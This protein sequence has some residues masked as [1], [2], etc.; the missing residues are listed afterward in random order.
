VKRNPQGKK[1]PLRYEDEKFHPSTRG[2]A[3]RASVSVS[4]K[5]PRGGYDRQ[6]ANDSAKQAKSSPPPPHSE[7]KPQ[8]PH[9]PKIKDRKLLRGFFRLAVI[10]F[11]IFW[12]WA[13]WS[14]WD[15]ALKDQTFNSHYNIAGYDS[16]PWPKEIAK[17][18]FLSLPVE[19]RQSLARAYFEKNIEGWAKAD[20]YD[21]DELREW[22]IK[23]ATLSLEEAP[24][25]ERHPFEDLPSYTVR[26]RNIPLKDMP[27]M[28]PWRMLIS[29]HGAE[30]L[31]VALVAALGTTL[32]VAG[33]FFVVRW[34]VRGFTKADTPSP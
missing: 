1:P 11:L 3:P 12:A 5:L 16:S 2:D 6:R 34:I 28:Q 31:L 32:I 21:P 17:D 10:F 25:E 20:F 29:R 19:E 22:F 15:W 7:P 14:T 33:C 26:Y 24:L 13:S 8:R 9:S 30:N 4:F 18:K 23:T 27:R